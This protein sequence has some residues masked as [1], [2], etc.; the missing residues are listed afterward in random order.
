[1]TA[2]I[3][4]S[5]DMSQTFETQTDGS[6]TGAGA[7]FKQRDENGVMRPVAYTS[8]MLNAAEQKYPTHDRELIAIV[9]AL[10]LW[11]PYLLGHHFAVLTD[12]YRYD[13]YTPSQSCHDGKPDEI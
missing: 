5:A 12:H 6:Q 2:L 8:P 1:M 9:Q 7:V 13:T 3:L 4:K 11:C 10:K